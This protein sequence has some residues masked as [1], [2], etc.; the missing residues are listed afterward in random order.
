[1]DTFLIPVYFFPYMG[2]GSPVEFLNPVPSHPNL[3]PANLTGVQAIGN[4]RCSSIPH[5]FSPTTHWRRFF[6]HGGDMDFSLTPSEPFKL[7]V[8]MSDYP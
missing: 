6:T 7:G 8:F 3:N 5:I 4:L 2:E 1:M